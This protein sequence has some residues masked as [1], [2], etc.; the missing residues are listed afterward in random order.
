MIEAARRP[1]LRLAEI[2]QTLAV[3]YGPRP[4]LGERAREVAT[5][6]NTGRASARLLPKFDTISYHDLWAQVRRDRRGLAQG[7]DH[8]VSP[9]DFVAIVGFA[10]SEYLKI[11]LVCG[12]LGLVS[13]PLQH[14]A[15]VSEMAP[16]IVEVEP[17]VLAVSVE[18]LDLAVESALDSKSLRHLVVL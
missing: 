15:A 7:P 4:A 12:Y 5:D 8:P 17:R 1:G 9:G 3:G 18:H 16:I 14:N 11:D 6:P 13:V 2:L 10:S